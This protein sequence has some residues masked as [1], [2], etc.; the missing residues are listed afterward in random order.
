MVHSVP[1]SMNLLVSLKYAFDPLEDTI[2]EESQ[3][4]YGRIFHIKDKSRP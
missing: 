1:R 4:S 2:L 3:S